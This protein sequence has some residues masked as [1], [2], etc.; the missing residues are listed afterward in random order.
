[1]FFFLPRMFIPGHGMAP[2]GKEIV[3][4]RT[5]VQ[6]RLYNAC[7]TCICTYSCLDTALSLPNDLLP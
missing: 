2:E 1:M 6:Q 4:N 5:K 7:A 3:A